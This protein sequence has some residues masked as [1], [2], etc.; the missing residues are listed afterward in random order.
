MKG[1]IAR[2]ISVAANSSV[3]AQ[4]IVYKQILLCTIYVS[5]ILL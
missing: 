1:R 4:N 5:S 2:I 3:A